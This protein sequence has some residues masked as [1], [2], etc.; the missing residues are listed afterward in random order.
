MAKPKRCVLNS[1]TLGKLADGLVGK[2]ID[3]ELRAIHDDMHDRGHDQK[4]RTLTIKLTFTPDANGIVDVKANVTKKLP[5][6]V[7]PRTVGKTSP[8]FNGVIFHPDNADNPDQMVLT[9]QDRTPYD[10]PAETEA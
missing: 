5:D 3:G 2:I 9:D 6:M 4:A 7:P 10:P 8:A 1:D